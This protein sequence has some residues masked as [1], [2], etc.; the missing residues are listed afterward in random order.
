[1]TTQIAQ[2]DANNKHNGKKPQSPMIEKLRDLKPGEMMVYYR[3]DFDRETVDREGDSERI[4]A[5][6]SILREL[7]EYAIRLRDDGAINID[8]QMIK[9]DAPQGPFWI[10]EYTAVGL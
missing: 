7:R 6:K 5:Y 9:G 3:G 4:K 8:A 10:R 2:C 1:M